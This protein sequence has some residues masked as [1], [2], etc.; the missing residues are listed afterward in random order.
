MTATALALEACSRA[1]EPTKVAPS[2][3]ATPTP[4]LKHF[5]RTSKTA[6]EWFV[7]H[8]L[9]QHSSGTTTQ[10]QS[11]GRPRSPTPARVRALERASGL[12]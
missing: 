6:H 8:L 7:Q 5:A 11:L 10:R 3:V 4:Y 9:A 1:I 12:P 2:N